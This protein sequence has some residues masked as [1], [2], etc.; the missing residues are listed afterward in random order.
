MP[1]K[2][3]P[4]P[5]KKSSLPPAQSVPMAPTKQFNVCRRTID[6]SGEKVVIYGTSGIGKT[7]LAATAPT[8]AFVPFDDGSR[9]INNPI[10]KEPLLYIPDV[11]TFQDLRDALN[12][13][14]VY[15]NCESIVIDTVTFVQAVCE[16]HIFATIKKTESNSSVTNLESYGY[17]KGYKHLVDQMR[18]FLGDCDR[19]VARKKN[20]IL[21][22]QQHA[23][24]VANAAGEDY[25]QDGPDLQ[26]NNQNS[27]RDEVIAWAD[28]IARI[29]YLDVTIS[30]KKA[31]GESKRAIFLAAAPHYIAKS[32]TLD[33]E[34]YGVISFESPKDDSFWTILFGS[35]K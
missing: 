35:K 28:H 16:P 27:V 25:I 6:T 7:N 21:L 4:P 19:L 12:S 20:V 10:T 31:I 26:H 22:A 30:Q 3:P 11:Q 13:P 1:L 34:Q 8:P 23:V 14:G 32:R 9:K 15:N 33:P 29:A 5:K 18:L 24:R 17:G 2:L